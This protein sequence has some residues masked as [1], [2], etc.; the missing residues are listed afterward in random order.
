MSAKPVI[1]EGEQSRGGA[2][3]IIKSNLNKVICIAKVLH[4]YDEE[5]LSRYVEKMK[6]SHNIEI[7]IFRPQKVRVV[8]RHVLLTAGIAGGI[9]FMAIF[10]H[11]LTIMIHDE[12]QFTSDIWAI[13]LIASVITFLIECGIMWREHIS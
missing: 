4:K 9:V 8:I 5:E 13:P 3:T 7:P 12:A 2:P 6:Y 10:L 11:N 1:E